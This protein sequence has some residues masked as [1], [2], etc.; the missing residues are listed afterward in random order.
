MYHLANLLHRK[1]KMWKDRSMRFWD[2]QMKVKVPDNELKSHHTDKK[3]A[4]I[5]YVRVEDRSEET[6]A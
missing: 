1:I 5:S 3:D 6:G 4:I 2:K